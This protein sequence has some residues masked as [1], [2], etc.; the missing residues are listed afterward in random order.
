MNEAKN[1]DKS[2]KEIIN[3]SSEKI[4]K[5]NIEDLSGSDHRSFSFRFWF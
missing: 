4:S 2:T 3:N 5:I 1:L